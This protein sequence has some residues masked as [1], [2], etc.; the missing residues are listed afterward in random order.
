V[1]GLREALR[2]F[3]GVDA[4]IEEPIR[5][6]AWWA[7][8]APPGETTASVLGVTT[9]LVSAEAQGAVLGSTATL[10][11]SH[12]IG[13]DQFGLPL[14]EDV[15]HQFTVSIISGQLACEQ[16]LDKVRGILDREKPAHTVYELCL[17]RPRM[18]VGWQS[19]VGVD[20]IVA[21]PPQPSR[22][23]DGAALVLGGELSAP[24]GA[25]LATGLNTRI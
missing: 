7:L 25:G 12:L 15:A 18:R 23:N 3:A 10:D 8:A 20:A 6:A 1:D 19:R 24:V 21:G 2:L 9:R 14:F 17:I 13:G 4:V 22:L 16:T 11:Q 5:Q